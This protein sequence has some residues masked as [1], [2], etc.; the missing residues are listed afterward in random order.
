[1]D[2]QRADIRVAPISQGRATVPV[3]LPT[4]SR[5]R[6]NLRHPLRPQMTL[7]GGDAE[8]GIGGAI[9]AIDATALD[10]LEEEALA[11]VLAVELEIFAVVV[12]VVEDVFAAQPFEEIGFEAEARFQIILIVG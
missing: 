12:A 6:S 3:S 11:E 8:L 10:D 1:M 5:V 2:R 4:D 7:L 9:A